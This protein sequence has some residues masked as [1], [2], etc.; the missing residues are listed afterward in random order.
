MITICHIPPGNNANPQTIQISQSAW[1]AHQAHGDTKGDC[2]NNRVKNTTPPE[3]YINKPYQP[4]KP[5]TKPK[6]P[7]TKPKKPL[8][9]P[10]KPVAKPS[11]SESKTSPVK[12]NIAAPTK[13]TSK[14]LN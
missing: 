10:K 2:S 4:K 5:V 8:A 3:Q 9:K 7:V 6:K 12:K 14:G 11:S 13:G 1:P